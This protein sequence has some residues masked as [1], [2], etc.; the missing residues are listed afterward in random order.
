LADA[1]LARGA[2]HVLAGHQVEAILLSVYRTTISP[3]LAPTGALEANRYFGAVLLE[4]AGGRQTVEQASE[5]FFAAVLRA[6]K[7]VMAA[8]MRCSCVGWFG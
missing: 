4:V 1:R 8:F 7:M 2:R 5:G 6:E 3:T